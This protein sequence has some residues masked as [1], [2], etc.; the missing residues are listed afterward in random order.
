[1]T[2]TPRRIEDLADE[3]ISEILTFL[4]GAEYLSN[5]SSPVNPHDL[6]SGLNGRPAHVYGEG[7]ELDRFRLVCKRFLR[8]STPRKFPRFVVR[9]SR[10]GFQRLEELLHMQL[11]C[12]VKYFTYMVRPFYQGSGWPQ[13]LDETD[14]DRFPAAQVHR[15]RLQDQT[16][17]LDGN[18]DRDM[19]R[20]A[21]VAFS[22]LQ[23]VK[24]LRVQDEADERLISQIR[25]RSLE[26]TV[27]LDWEPACTRAVTNL[28]ISLLASNCTS[29]RF[30][31]P[32]ISPEATVRLLQTPSATL[33]AL[34][35]RLACLDVTFHSKMDLTS[36][37]KLLSQAFHDF[38]LAAKNLTAIHLGFATAAPLDLP[39]EQIFHHIQWKR[40][41]TLSIQGW[42]VTSQELIALISR[43]S[44]QLRDIRLTSIF[45][46][47]GSRW[48]DVLSVLHDDMDEVE[49]IDLREINYVKHF[50]AV[51]APN[52]SLNGHGNGYGIGNGNGN[53][54]G[55]GSAGF[56]P[57]LPLS[58]IVNHNT[59]PNSPSPP[60][61]QPSF[62]QA[63]LNT[64]YLSFALRGHTRRSFS[65][66]TLES[67]RTLT[68]DD[69]RDDGIT[70]SYDQRLFWEAWVLSSLSKVA[71]RRN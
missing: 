41:R 1:M 20:K 3:L 42:R 68:A 67:L 39:L 34:G 70:V 31:G 6:S 52:G 33:S 25:E 18:H 49:Q 50:D 38:L 63:V 8:I 10:R 7:C 61:P 14:S 56:Y 9:F 43:H 66:S 32:Q 28:A 27:G 23:Q 4:L 12:H 2:E 30:V 48:R 37:M 40:L 53:G 64:D 19:L 47:E 60:S 71:R 24:L 36:H 59:S 55:T 17:I 57:P 58:I 51:S 46:H 21:M 69:L 65:P 45:L 29:V 22:S 11:A 54:N 5:T 15:A 13:L 62:H 26:G 35:A 44:R 16:R